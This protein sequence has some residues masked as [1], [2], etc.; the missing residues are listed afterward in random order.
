MGLWVIGGVGQQTVLLCQG[1]GIRGRNLS[2]LI[3]REAEGK[4]A[5][6]G[7][8]CPAQACSPVSLKADW[9]LAH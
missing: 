8:G 4:E 2:D 3:G 9:H 1:G 6:E 5:E 7:G